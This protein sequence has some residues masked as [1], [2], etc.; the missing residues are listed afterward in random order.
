MEANADSSPRQ[1]VKALWKLC[2]NDSDAFT[3]LYFR[4]RY[5]DEVNQCLQEEGRVVSALQLLPY[6]LT[7]LGTTLKADYISGACT[8]PHYRKHGLMRKLLQQSF[9]HS[10]RNGVDLSFLIPA[11]PWLI[12]YYARSG[13]AP[14]F[15]CTRRLFTTAG[16]PTSPYPLHLEKTTQYRPAAYTYLLA[17]QARRPCCILHSEADWRVVLANLAQFGGAVYT[18]SGDKKETDKE[19]GNQ[20]A[21]AS[22]ACSDRHE[23]LSSEAHNPATDTS[24]EIHALAIAYPTEADGLVVGELLADNTALETQLLHAICHDRAATTLCVQT[25]PQADAPCLNMGMARLVRIPHIM[26]L[27]A[28]AHPATT[29]EFTLTDNDLPANTGHYTL[30]GGTCQFTPGAAPARARM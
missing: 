25:P 18:L 21:D 28:Q 3:D 14:V 11:E 20:A 13:Y 15:Q 26:Q 2:F 17:K 10:Y 8:H 30:R 1:Q 6:T 9:R 23:T 29:M 12:D 7:F 22:G 19:A 5:S 16:T 27:Y 24:N 4:L